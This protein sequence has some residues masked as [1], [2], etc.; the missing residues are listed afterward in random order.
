MTDFVKQDEVASQTA[1][2]EEFGSGSF[3]VTQTEQQA[4]LTA[5]LNDASQ[6]I[7]DAKASFE[8]TGIESKANVPEI[9]ITYTKVTKS[10][11]RK[12]NVDYQEVPGVS[13]ATH[14]GP[15][16]RVLRNK[17]GEVYFTLLD[18]NRVNAQ[19]ERGFSAIKFPGILSFR[20]ADTQAQRDALAKAR[21]YATGA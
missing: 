11:A 13:Y 17:L 19:G 6:R 20:Y 21:N 15:A 5:Y 12:A 7:A 4:M 10:K 18:A 16:V 3:A 9:E 14:K 8:R 1:K 2:L